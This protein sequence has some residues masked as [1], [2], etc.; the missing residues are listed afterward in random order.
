MTMKMHATGEI[1]IKLENIWPFQQKTEMA[2]CCDSS[3]HHKGD[4]PT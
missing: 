2:E 1:I 4:M 3:D